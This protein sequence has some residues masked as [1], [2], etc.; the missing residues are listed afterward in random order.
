M[1]KRCTT[2][3]ESS[4]HKHC[5][6]PGCDFDAPNA[7]VLEK[8]HDE[9]HF[10]CA[11]CKHILPSQTKLT[12]HYEMCKFDV[13]CPDCGK[14]C[15]GQIQLVLHMEACVNSSK[16][17]AVADDVSNVSHVSIASSYHTDNLQPGCAAVQ[18]SG[19]STLL[20]C[21]VCADS[22]PSHTALIRHLESGCC[23]VLPDPTLLTLCLGKWWYSPLFMDLDLHAQIRR[24]E[25]D[26]RETT[27]WMEQGFL[28]PFACRDENCNVSFARFSEFVGHVEG[29]KC[30]WGIERLRL[31]MLSV[32]M[33]AMLKRKDSATA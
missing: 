16:D 14:L 17:D 23:S 21:F 31:D 24:N 33:A 27:N 26:L 15:A 20:M 1:N 30:R 19:G 9:D 2:T 13:P 10:R 7:R 12:Q 18:S 5:L 3:N 22:M 28:R 8:H 4:E 29:G 11:G 25:I 6:Q 32:E